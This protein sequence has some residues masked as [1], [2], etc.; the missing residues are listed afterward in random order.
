MSGIK[1]KPLF[2]R[3]LLKQK[4]VETKTSSGIIIPESSKE[5]PLIGIVVAVGD[6]K[7]GEPM[8]VKVG[9]EVTF[10]Q[11]VGTEIEIEK[12]KYLIMREN[13]LFGIL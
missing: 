3:V 12:V 4:E 7:P 8:T 9:D 13:E 1:F 10:G 6:G 11:Y 2:D 5:K